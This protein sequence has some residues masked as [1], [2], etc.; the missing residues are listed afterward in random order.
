[1][2]ELISDGGVCRTAPATP[3]LL[4]SYHLNHCMLF[5]MGKVSQLLEELESSFWD[6]IVFHC[7]DTKYAATY[8]LAPICKII[9]NQAHTENADITT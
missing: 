9:R 6:Q 8:V 5:T 1:M 4:K 2:N 3:G 7:N